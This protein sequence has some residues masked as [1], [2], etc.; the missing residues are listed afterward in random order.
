MKKLWIMLMATI[1]V[2]MAQ[3]QTWKYIVSGGDL[4]DENTCLE[5]QCNTEGYVVEKGY[6][7][8]VA[9]AGTEGTNGIAVVC[10]ASS[11]Q[12]WDP[13][14]WIVLSEPVT[15]GERIKVDFDYK[16][17][18]PMNVSTNFQ[19]ADGMIYDGDGI[20]VLE[21]NEEWQHFSQTISLPSANQW[22]S[23]T[24]VSRICFL[25]GNMD[26]S[27]T[28]DV[29]FYIDNVSVQK[30]EWE[31]AEVTG[32]CGVGLK[33]SFNQATGVLTIDGEGT[34]DPYQQ[35]GSTE[36][37][38]PNTPWY[39]YH[40]Q[41]KSLYV[42]ASITSTSNY[43]FA[44]LDQ[45]TY[46][47]LPSTL[48]TMGVYTFSKCSALK[49]ITLPE[50][51]TKFGIGT[52]S[53]SGLTIVI[54]P[55]KIT[56][57]PQKGFYKCKQLE[58]I[59]LPTNMSMI[60]ISAFEECDHLTSVA[61]P[62]GLKTIDIKAFYNSGLT[63]VEIPQA[64][65]TIGENAFA[66]STLESVTFNGVP[67][68]IREQVF[69]GCDYL[70]QVHLPEGFTTIPYATFL[71]CCSLTS[72]T[73]PSTL[74]TIGSYAF[75]GC[76][77]EWVTSLAVLPPACDEN[78]FDYN[79]EIDKTPANLVVPDGCKV[80][81]NNAWPWASFQEIYQMEP[82]MPEVMAG[83]CGENVTWSIDPD[84]SILTIEG[85]GAMTNFDYRNDE[86]APWARYRSYFQHVVVG[87]G[88]TTIGDYAF[89]ETYITDIMLPEGI[90]SIGNDAFWGCSNL[91]A[92]SLP[93]TLKEIHFGAFVACNSLESIVIPEGVK[94][95]DA[96]VFGQCS[97]LTQVTIPSTVES[98]GRL[99]FAYCESLEEIVIPAN[100]KSIDTYAFGMCPLLKDVT[101]LST[102]P[103]T[104]AADAFDTATLG[105]EQVIPATLHVPA[106][107]LEN[108]TEAEVWKTFSSIVPIKAEHEWECTHIQG[109]VNGDGK[110]TI[111]DVNRLV[112]IL[113]KLKI[114]N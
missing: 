53:E 92:I 45:L 17:T 28:E 23:A 57:I 104:L 81:Y 113:K 1:C 84:L 14:M 80:N 77:L 11:T 111:A 109:D 63:S 88:V 93:S 46:V 48:K 19:N 13:Q 105:A 95:I 58:A 4:E 32:E 72:I 30:E 97:A 41:I 31:N 70:T 8:P 75:W 114:E 35:V 51:L 100:V 56:S 3:A 60:G 27:R 73:L 85:T 15:E 54:L 59:S 49:K 22:V 103:P 69:A 55:S 66:L 99:A 71:E 65:E 9:G 78:A 107:K 47:K 38:I 6:P 52:F 112:E 91:S 34:M 10:P 89:M 108:Y 24:D 79:S 44:G 74:T 96:Q 12:M 101:C 2:G 37:K 102:T 50:S 33:W 76:S 7:T 83:T 20:G 67:K 106:G 64:V 61:L 42:N 86:K 87:Q 40:E 21:C 29:T 90:E 94:K 43:A 110:V 16:A 25:L 36:G 39:K 98:I 68:E 18:M 82:E 62:E 26:G 5:V